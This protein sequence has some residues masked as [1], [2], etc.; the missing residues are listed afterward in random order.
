MPYERP[1]AGVYVTA[2]KVTPHNAPST[3]NGFVGAAVKQKA[4]SWSAAFSAT[5]SIAIS[6]RFHLR[7]KGEKQ[8]PNNTYG[9][10]TAAT[11]GAPV[12]IAT[13][14][15]VL[16]LTGPASG[17]NLPFGRVSG[18]PGDAQGCP[19]GQIRIDLDQ[20]DTITTP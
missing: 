5:P 13:T 12:Y 7:T 6:E 4:L 17:T 19:T 9:N 11:L 20:K 1:G 2:T 15:N 18:L 8:F 16:T 10:L 14:T 3:E